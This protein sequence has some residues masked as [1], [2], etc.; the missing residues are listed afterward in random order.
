M[1]YLL[2]SVLLACAVMPAAA[3]D[4]ATLLVLQPARVYDPGAGEVHD[5]WVVV[6][7][8]ERI[9]AVGPRSRTEAP[10]GARVIALP[11]LTLLPGLID[12]HYHRGSLK[13]PNLFLNNGVTSVRDPGAWNQSYDPV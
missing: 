11:G 4:P 3:Q 10:A 6:V 2:P 8:G 7:R 13:L 1:R 9:E 12:A 5:D